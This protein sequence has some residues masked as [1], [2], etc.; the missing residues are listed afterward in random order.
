MSLLKKTTS[1]P[2]CSEKLDSYNYSFCPYCGNKIPEKEIIK[3]EDIFAIECRSPSTEGLI[4]EQHVVVYIIKITNGWARID[5]HS[6][7]SEKDIK[8]FLEEHKTDFTEIKNNRQTDYFFNN[9]YP[10]DRLDVVYDYEED[11][12]SIDLLDVN[13]LLS[14]NGGR[15][16]NLSFELKPFTFNLY[17]GFG[18]GEDTNAPILYSFTD[19][20]YK[21]IESFM[22]L[23]VVNLYDQTISYD[24]CPYG[25]RDVIDKTID[26]F[27]E[28]HP[29]DYA[30]IQLAETLKD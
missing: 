18:I 13:I 29:E 11:E 27:K 15:G 6:D 22:V 10:I 26:L 24:F 28:K 19:I 9:Q 23:P 2:S 21:C 7:I 25:L 14:H 16:K 20:L 12:G 5:A 17:R 4:Q 1:C 8:E 30:S 3:L